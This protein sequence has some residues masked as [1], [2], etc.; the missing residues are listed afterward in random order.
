MLI[1][2]IS[3]YLTLL[4]KTA[5]LEKSLELLR[6]IRESSEESSARHR[7]RFLTQKC[8]ADIIRRILQTADT[9]E[10]YR[11]LLRATYLAYSDG[12]FVSPSDAGLTA[13]AINSVD[14][15]FLGDGSCAESACKDDLEDLQS[16]LEGLLTSLCVL[17][18]LDGSSSSGGLTDVLSACTKLWSES[19]GPSRSQKISSKRLLG[20]QSLE[21]DGSEP[22]DISSSTRQPR[23]RRKTSVSDSATSI[24]GNADVPKKQS[25][26]A[27]VRSFLARCGSFELSRDVDSHRKA[28]KPIGKVESSSRKRRAI[29]QV[30]IFMKRYRQS[31]GSPLSPSL[32]SDG[33]ITNFGPTSGSTSLNIVG[34]GMKTESLASKSPLLRVSRPANSKKKTKIRTSAPQSA[35]TKKT[36]KTA[37]TAIQITRATSFSS[38]KARVREALRLFM[39]TRRHLEAEQAR[40]STKKHEAVEAVRVFLQR[41]QR[42]VLE[43]SRRCPTDSAPA[44]SVPCGDSALETGANISV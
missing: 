13:A 29:E 18:K 2:Y 17:A 27:A 33:S 14:R 36:T 25:A 37:T 40:R 31:S 39:R 41:R 38:R 30:G 24:V 28:N 4:Y 15:V 42:L 6:F 7:M 20:T 11:S 9:Q 3:F 34:P 10:E 35:P 21:S 43:Q 26:L 23:K 32:T 16:V 22:V 44:P 1:Q 19:S 8:I 5:A 12:G